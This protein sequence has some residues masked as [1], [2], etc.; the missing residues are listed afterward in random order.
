MLIHNKLLHGCI[1][2]LP[3]AGTLHSY[4][5]KFEI[6]SAYNSK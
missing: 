2:V 5:I 6:V 3:F 4:E 1:V